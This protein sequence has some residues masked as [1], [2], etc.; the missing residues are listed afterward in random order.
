MLCD[1]KKHVISPVEHYARSLFRRV[2]EPQWVA[3]EQ[4]LVGEIV[5]AGG[6]SKT[7]VHLRLKD[8]AGT[9]LDHRHQHRA[10]ARRGASAFSREGASCECEQN[11][12]T[13]QLRKLKLLGFVNYKPTFD[14]K[15]FAG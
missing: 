4:Y 9:A 8:F 1:L 11:L 12:R 15:A 5:E 3:V 14:P 10:T 7:N 6:S 13:G 2:A